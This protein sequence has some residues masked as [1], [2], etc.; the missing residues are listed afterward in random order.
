M[1]DYLYANVIAMN[2][3][4]CGDN[5]EILKTMDDNS[6][7]LTVTSPPYDG[8]RDYNGYSFDFEGIAQQLYRVTKEGGVIVWVVGDAVV[9]GSETGTS[10]RQALHFME[11]GLRL[12]DTM[13]YS[14]KGSSLP[15]PTRYFQKFEY[16]FVL[17]KGKPN[18]VNLIKDR[19]N[20]SAGAQKRTHNRNPTTGVVEYRN[21]VRYVG[22]YGLRYNIWEYS[23]SSQSSADKISFNHPATFP[24]KLAYDHIM[25]WSNEGD[26]ILDPF[27]GSGTTCKMAKQLNRNYI[28]IDISQEYIDIAKERLNDSM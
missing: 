4:I 21:E 6:I 13:L 14:K 26:V 23:T 7:D 27:V 10:F 5:I 22:E 17:S 1:V 15:D 28:G 2:E 25:S 18:T 20:K 12:H 16:M 11:I 19:K 3:L 24:E 9:K 8:L